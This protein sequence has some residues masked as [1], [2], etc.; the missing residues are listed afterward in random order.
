MKRIAYWSFCLGAVLLFS[1]F[2]LTTVGCGSSS[3]QIRFVHAGFDPD[4]TARAYAKEIEQLL[5]EPKP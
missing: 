3:T 5:R 4:K 1:V 2:T